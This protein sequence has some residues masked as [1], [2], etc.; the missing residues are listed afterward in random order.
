MVEAQRWGGFEPAQPLGAASVTTSAHEFRR[1][2]A[3]AKKIIPTPEFKVALTLSRAETETLMAIFQKIGGSPATTR[4]R[5]VDAMREALE[6]LNI[7]DKAADLTI[8]CGALY[9]Q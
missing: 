4:R 5:H 2:M 1:I 7:A 8:N 3:T 6:E 9:F